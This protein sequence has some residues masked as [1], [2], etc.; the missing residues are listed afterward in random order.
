MVKDFKQRIEWTLALVSIL[1]Q[2]DGVYFTDVNLPQ[3][4]DAVKMVNYTK[5]EPLQCSV[6]FHATCINGL[7]EQVIV[8]LY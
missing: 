2:L 6:V 5:S 4:S 1:I 7:Q 3:K 8:S